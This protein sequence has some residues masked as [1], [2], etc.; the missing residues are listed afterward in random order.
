[1]VRVHELEADNVVLIGI[2]ERNIK[3]LESSAKT[4]RA[5]APNAGRFYLPALEVIG[6]AQDDIKRS[7]EFLDRIFSEGNYP[8][9]EGNYPK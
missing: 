4:L 5:L 3:S 9:L 8:D 6:K 1:M 2:A 7:R